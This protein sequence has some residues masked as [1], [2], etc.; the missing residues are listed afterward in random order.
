MAV[1][2]AETADRRSKRARKDKTS[3]GME[4]ESKKDK[5]ERKRKARA[6]AG[7]GEK[8]DRKE[9]KKKRKVEEEGWASVEDRGEEKKK[10]KRSRHD[11]EAAEVAADGE[12]AEEAVEASAEPTMKKRKHKR[13]DTD[14]DIPAPP[15]GLVEDVKKSKKKLRSK[16]NALEDKE[17][18]VEKKKHKKSTSDTHGDEEEG[19]RS[20]SKKR[21]RSKNHTTYPDPAEDGSPSEQASKALGYARSQFSDPETWKFNKARQNWLIR[22]VWSIESVPDAYMPL[23][24]H[25][26]SKV[27]G[28]VRENLLEVC[29]KTLTAAG[30]SDIIAELSEKPPL[31]SIL[32]TS[33]PAEG[34]QATP[35][36]VEQPEPFAPAVD[37]IKCA[38][39][40]VLLQALS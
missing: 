37:E 9:K 40:Q 2:L 1:E 17:A 31:K 35:S 15:E 21:K 24:A 38:R 26:L 19:E 13:K 5:S 7:D 11:D 10:K 22:N 18:P 3:E 16:E 23:V 36:A 14:A 27:Q 33:K 20:K 32:K 12:P 8:E 6:E 30:P 28:G 4:K 39:A 29:S 25:Y 34:E